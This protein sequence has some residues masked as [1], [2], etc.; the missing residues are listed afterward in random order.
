MGASLKDPERTPATGIRSR[1]GFVQQ[2][3]SGKAP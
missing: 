2:G 1:G 3:V